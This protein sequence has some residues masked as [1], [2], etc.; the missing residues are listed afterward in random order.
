MLT[1]NS[2]SPSYKAVSCKNSYSKVGLV[3][4]IMKTTSNVS[5]DCQVLAQL[6]FSLR[7]IIINSQQQPVRPGGYFMYHQVEHKKILHS[8]QSVFFYVHVTMHR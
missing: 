2:A 3:N 5:C 6:R 4:S 1:V 7:Q 8:T